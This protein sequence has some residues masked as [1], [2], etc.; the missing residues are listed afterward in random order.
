MLLCRD[1]STLW[2]ALHVNMVEI[3]A[4]CSDENVK[5]LVSYQWI[6]WKRRT[7]MVGELLIKGEL[8]KRLDKKLVSLRKSC[9]S[10]FS[11]AVWHAGLR[12]LRENWRFLEC[13][14]Q[15][16]LCGKRL[17]SYHNKRYIQT[18]YR[19]SSNTSRIWHLYVTMLWLY[20]VVGSSDVN[21]VE[22][23]KRQNSR[24]IN[25]FDKVYKKTSVSNIIPTRD[26]YVE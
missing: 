14:D 11:D 2:E 19:R 5:I 12:S 25:G 21:M 18:P 20:H 15:S 17:I 16:F 26:S 8:H 7:K 13:L 24:D 3:G 4:R 22:R 9:A 6:G 23:Q 1:Y 10:K